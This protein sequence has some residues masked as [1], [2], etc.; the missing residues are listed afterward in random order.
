MKIN[1]AALTEAATL[2]NQI[3]S[4]QAQLEEFNTK[5]TEVGKQLTPLVSQYNKLVG[6]LSMTKGVKVAKSS[7]KG[8]RHVS[9]EQKAKISAGLKAKWAE[10]KAAKASPVALAA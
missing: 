7:R 10:R 9:P 1:S 4:L 8:S 6:S 3:E 5:S 2:A